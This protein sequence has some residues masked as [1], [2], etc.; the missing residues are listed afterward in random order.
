MKFK[1]IHKHKNLYSVRRMCKLLEVS[2]SGYYA[3]KKN[4]P[5]KQ[6]EQDAEDTKWIKKEFDNSL[7]TYGSR[8][9]QVALKKQG[10]YLSRRRINFLMKKASLMA[11][12][13]EKWHPRTTEQ[14]LR[15]R[16]A[17]NLL[18]QDF[19]A[20]SPNEKWVTDITY[21]DTK[22]GWYYLAV[23]LDLYSRSV[24]GWGMSAKID[25]A[26]VLSA[27]QMAI[28]RRRPGKGLLHHS[29]R[30]SQYTS[31]DY[32]DELEKAGC[33]IS[34]SGTG[35]CYDNAAME[36]FFS[37]LKTESVS[38]RFESRKE[39]RTKLFWYIESW[40]NRTRIHSSLG[41]LSPLAYEHQFRQI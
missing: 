13:R 35:N 34:M 21:I 17:P 36:S 30:G 15:N 38:Y 7:Q 4:G 5:N 22:E 26:L 9:I 37:T 8:R 24:V 12:K 31:N 10:I 32:L 6:C 33:R 27:L 3:W 1:F 2:A 28:Y 11:K 18:G 14:D 25:R 41:Y 40:Y 19:K 23:V 20:S 29:D 16:I 39:A